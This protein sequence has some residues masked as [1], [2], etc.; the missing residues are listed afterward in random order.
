MNALTAD[1]SILSLCVCILNRYTDS[2]NNNNNRMVSQY[3]RERLRGNVKIFS[4]LALFSIG[5]YAFSMYKMG[6]NDFK[7]INDFGHQ[8]TAE[9]ENQ[10]KVL[11]KRLR[12]S[13]DQQQQQQ[14]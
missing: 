11:K 13:G 6:M 12:G 14:Q 5:V 3:H 10:G 2:N 4:A 7:D 1:L 8:I 9:E